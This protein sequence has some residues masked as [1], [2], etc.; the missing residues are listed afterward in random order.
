MPLDTISKSSPPHVAVRYGDTI[1]LFAR[2]KYAATEG[3]G[4]YVGTFEGSKRFLASKNPQK[5][6]ELACIPPIAPCAAK[7]FYE[8]TYMSN[9]TTNISL[10]NI[11]SNGD[12]VVLQDADGRVWNN[13]MGVGPSTKNGCFGPKESNTP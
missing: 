10:D 7:Q 11:I 5:Q 9:S 2:S 12:V 4:G 13:K 1:R 3:T 8:K 6:D